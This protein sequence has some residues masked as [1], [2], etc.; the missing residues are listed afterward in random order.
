[1]NAAW[2]VY[3]RMLDDHE[4]WPVTASQLPG[5]FIELGLKE[6]CL[7]LLKHLPCFDIVYHL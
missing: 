4:L 3:W 6:D 1:M 2:D 5:S 7:L